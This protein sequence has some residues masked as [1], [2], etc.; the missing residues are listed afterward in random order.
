MKF[1]PS[2][3]DGTKYDIEEEESPVAAER[4]EETM[5]TANQGRRLP[6]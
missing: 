3:F 6:W 4:R 2:V 5:K 1:Y